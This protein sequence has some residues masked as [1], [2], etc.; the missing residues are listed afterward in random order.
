[1]YHT[2]KIVY[3]PTLFKFPIYIPACTLP[4]FIK[5]IATRYN[6]LI[7]C[8]YGGGGELCSPQPLDET[9]YYLQVILAILD[10]F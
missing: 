5:E 8:S 1:M 2:R 9:L 4:D 10:K 3:L 7:I 6:Q